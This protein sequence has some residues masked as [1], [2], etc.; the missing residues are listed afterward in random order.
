MLLVSKDPPAA[1]AHLMRILEA[2][3]ILIVERGAHG[4]SGDLDDY[5]LVI[6]NNWDLESIPLSRER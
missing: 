2:N 6:L 4:P 5:Q 1:E 3:S